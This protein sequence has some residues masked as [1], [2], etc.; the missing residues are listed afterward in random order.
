MC[1]SDLGCYKKLR[2]L[3]Q[4]ELLPSA[5]V[6]YRKGALDEA[7]VTRIRNGLIDCVNTPIGKMFS[8]FWQLK[9]FEDVS[10]AYHA[11]VAKSLAAYPEPKNLPAAPP[12]PAN[13][14]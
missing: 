12:A 2:V 5:V 14:K 11:T 3:A 6:V 8:L 10:T 4:S 9:G 1:S 7:T 13:M